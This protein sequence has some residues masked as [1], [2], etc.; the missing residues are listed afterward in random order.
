MKFRPVGT[1]MFH[2][3]EQTDRQTNKRIYTDTDT[4]DGDNS[5]F[6]QFFER[7]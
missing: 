6:S 5:S 1:G 2:A 3:N 7:A 4:D